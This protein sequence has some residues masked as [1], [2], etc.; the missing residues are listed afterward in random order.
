MNKMLV[1]KQ[2]AEN[3]QVVVASQS[4]NVSLNRTASD[5]KPNLNRTNEMDESQLNDENPGN[6]NSL[7][8]DGQSSTRFQC[9][10]CPCT[11][12]R[13]SDLTKH[14]KL[15]HAVY[16]NNIQEYL[17]KN[18]NN[19]NA[20]KEVNEIQNE[21]NLN[22][23]SN[24]SLSNRNFNQ[25]QRKNSVVYEGVKK[26]DEPTIQEPCGGDG[27]E[28]PYCSFRSKG[29]DTEYIA[30]VKEHLCGKAFRCVLC[31]SVYKYRGDCVVHLK[32]KHQKA[33]ML[34]HSYVDRFNLDHLQISQ[35]YYL[36]KPKQNDDFEN[37]EKLFGCA[38]CDYKA[39]Y[40]GDVFKHQTRRHP[41]SAKSVQALGNMNASNLNESMSENNS[42]NNS[43]NGTT[44]HQNDGDSM[45]MDDNSYMQNNQ[46]TSNMD[47][48]DDLN[49]Q[50]DADYL[51]YS[52][53]QQDDMYAADTFYDE[54]E[55]FFNEQANGE[56]FAQDELVNAEEEEAS[57]TSNNQFSSN[58]ND[59]SDLA[60]SKF[61]CK[62]CTFVGKNHAKLQLHLA[63]HYNLKQYMCPI[64]KRRANFKWD[65]QKHMRKI[66][67]D[68]QSEVIRLS[69]N[70]A[71]QSISS[72]MNNSTIANASTSV[73]DSQNGMRSHDAK[74]HETHHHTEFFN[75][76]QTLDIIKDRKFKCSLCLRTS[77]WQW[78]IRK[79]LRTVHKGKLGHVVNLRPNE[80]NT[81]SALPLKN[82]SHVSISTYNVMN[83]N[84]NQLINKLKTYNESISNSNSNGYFNH[85]ANSTNE[86][87]HAGTC[88]NSFKCTFCPYQH[89]SKLKMRRHILTHYH[90]DIQLKH[91]PIYK[92]HKC[93]FKSQWQYM[94]K[95]HILVVH[96]HNSSA[97]NVHFVNVTTKK[98]VP[99]KIRVNFG[100]K[101]DRHVSKN[102]MN[103]H[104]EPCEMN[105]FAN[106]AIDSMQNNKF[107]LENNNH[108][109]EDEH[110]QNTTSQYEDDYLL[111]NCDQIDEFDGNN[112]TSMNDFDSEEK[113]QESIILTDHDGQK[114]K[115]NYLVTNTSSST[116][117]NHTFPNNMP[118]KKMY[119][120]I[121]CPYKTNNYCNFKQH[122]FQHRFQ[123]GSFKC[124]YC[125]YYVKMLRLLK[126]HEILHS[127]F[128]PRENGNTRK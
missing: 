67:N 40:K 98:R 62:F 59:S 99:V 14:L 4:L 79:H 63:T 124:R 72:Y 119:F 96:H 13:S 115:V 31:N 123:N 43:F 24:K 116:S 39:N 37:D 101:Q 42:A 50:N 44:N 112:M 103:N 68:H 20:F 100:N 70:E 18:A 7:A 5:L 90:F 30:H 80:S 22:D 51:D 9:N 48:S 41:G 23:D 83:E 17:R 88:D 126:Q 52:S 111:N 33:D 66:H 10:L 57:S 36:L 8:A 114:F 89:L 85:N 84:S 58:V 82:E 2:Q 34:A 71:R 81:D 29:N 3:G 15:K 110:Y 109:L 54:E 47:N 97:T 27:Y 118:R 122:L 120:C 102:N 49:T 104:N 106:R 127:E 108:D 45:Y 55:D 91:S 77:K 107:E 46:L 25:I 121:S 65:I 60:R 95:K 117:A 11:Y 1:K 94:V 87:N 93:S 61:Q 105:G 6:N 38:Y 69:E 75:N 56:E 64:C 28:C 74:Q 78:D 86:L 73:N 32:R 19:N 128:E 26:I 16:T 125:P 12:K 76:R 21:Q 113:K 53:Q 35:I 92:C